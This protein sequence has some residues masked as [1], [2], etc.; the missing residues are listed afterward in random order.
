M[1]KSEIFAKASSIAGAIWDDRD[2]TG[3]L[4]SQLDTVASWNNMGTDG[5]LTDSDRAELRA[6]A[7]AAKEAGL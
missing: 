3:T 4:A 6:L 1:T 2:K 7:T 5:D